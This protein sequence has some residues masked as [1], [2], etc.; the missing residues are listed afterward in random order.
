MKKRWNTRRIIPVSLALALILGCGAVFAYMFMRT[1][2]LKTQL[3]P[4]VVACEVIETAEGN[5]TVKNTGNVDAYLRVRLVTYWGIED[6]E[7]KIKVAPEPSQELSVSHNGDDW[8]A[9]SE[10]TFYYKVPVAPGGVTTILLTAPIELGMKNGYKQ[11]LDVF[12]EAI[13]S[14][15][16]DAVKEVW[17]V[18]MDTDGATIKSSP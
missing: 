11:V 10:N 13:Q 12:G 8:E 17:P 3:I 5:Y 4:A 6:S 2:T 15:P 18:T 16:T 14:K 1:P 9:G 7:G